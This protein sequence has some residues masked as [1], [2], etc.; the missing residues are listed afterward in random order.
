MRTV[1]FGVA[2]SLDNFIARK[3]HSVDWLHWSKDV[4]AITNEMWPKFDTVVMGRKTY[5]AAVAAGG[6]AY[7]NVINYVFSR[8]LRADSISQVEIIAEDAA[9]FVAHLKEKPGKGI[10]VI[11]G[12]ELAN[13]LF[14]ADLIDEVGL[15][16]HPIFLG[17][18]IPAFH[19]LQHVI[20]L[21][22]VESRVLD[23][24]CVFVMY[25]VPH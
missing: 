18:G 14:V 24:G 12:G 13:A 20:R 5:E 10:C 23:G 9:D 7:P 16:I 1:T 8:T 22:L 2:C 6:G 21:E 17:D 15:N 11:G 3:D 25:R 4:V 19:E